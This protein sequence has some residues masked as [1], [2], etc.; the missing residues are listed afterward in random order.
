MADVYDVPKVRVNASML[1][2]Y[3][4]K[5][6]CFV[7]Q[8]EKVHP[9]GRS[10]SL[11]DGEGKTASVE[12]NDPL[13]EELSGVVEVLGRVTNKAT[14]TAT[15]YT[16]YREDQNSFDLGLYNEALKVIHDFPQYYPFEVTAR[17]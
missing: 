16:L 15:T 10:F 12:L 5:P 1:S 14:I 9:T 13:E 11:R 6:V 2:Q 3:I 8:V 7:G 17:D 4:S